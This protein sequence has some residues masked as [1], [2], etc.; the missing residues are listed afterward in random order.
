VALADFRGQATAVL[1][2]NPG[3]GFCQRMLPGLKAREENPPQ[4]APKLILVSSGDPEENRG[5]GLRSPI[6]LDRGFQ[7]G[8][9]FGATGT[10]SAILI[11]A[12]G[13][14]ASKL[15]VG[16]SEVL[17]LL[18]PIDPADCENCVADCKEH[19]GGEACVAVCVMAGKC[20]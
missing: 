7:V 4:D 16:A 18:N 6:L 19:G 10:P 9:A 3:C 13:N 11:D 2:W 14:V 5:Q 1:F 8:T 20:G 15:G 12:R 17:G